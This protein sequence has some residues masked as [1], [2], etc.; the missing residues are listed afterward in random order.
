MERYRK[1]FF[2]ALGILA[3]TVGLVGLVNYMLDPYGL[4][5]ERFYLSIYRT[6]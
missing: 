3:A 6:Q 2:L 1:W 4:L 5:K